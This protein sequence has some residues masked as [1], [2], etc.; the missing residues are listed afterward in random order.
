MPYP[1]KMRSRT[2]DT[3]DVRGLPD[4]HLRWLQRIVEHLKQQ[5]PNRAKKQRADIVFA[6]HDSDVVGGE[7]DRANAYE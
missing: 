6:T 1:T 3:L 5:T 7:F 4:Q 2:M